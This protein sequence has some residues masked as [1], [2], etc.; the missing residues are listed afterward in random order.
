M[1]TCHQ[2]P[3]KLMWCMKCTHYDTVIVTSKSNE[4]IDMKIYM[5]LVGG[6]SRIERTQLLVSSPHC[7][8]EYWDAV[9]NIGCARKQGTF[10]F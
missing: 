2:R 1:G 3:R 8:V 9:G 6:G 5:N 4:I 10:A 7:S